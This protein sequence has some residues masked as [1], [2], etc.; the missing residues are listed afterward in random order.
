MSIYLVLDVSWIHNVE[1]RCLDPNLDIKEILTITASGVLGDTE[2][3][4][5]WATFYRAH[6][7]EYCTGNINDKAE[8]H[9]ISICKEI[10][11]RYTY[12]LNEALSNIYE[13][14]VVKE[15]L[16]PEEWV[17]KDSLMLKMLDV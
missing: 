16:M 6:Y 1:R 17:D 15:Y 5:L 2:N 14:Q 12:T 3:T 9:F 4:E 8:E 11:E 7:D 13:I 10:K